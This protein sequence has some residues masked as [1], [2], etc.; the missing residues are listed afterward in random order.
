[1]M[2]STFMD[3]IKLKN[4]AEQEIKDFLYDRYAN[5]ESDFDPSEMIERLPEKLKM[6]YYLDAY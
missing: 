3:L 4:G 2:F 5:S 6:E 1:M